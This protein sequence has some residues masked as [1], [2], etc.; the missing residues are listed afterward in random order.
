MHGSMEEIIGALSMEPTLVLPS[1]VQAGLVVEKGA[2]RLDNVKMQA[3]AVR[4]YSQQLYS[5][6]NQE[7]GQAGRQAARVFGWA[8][9][10]GTAESGNCGL[11]RAE[12]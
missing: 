12:R 1:D 8:V 2:S 10:P 11:K 5:A 7:V 4:I 3:V 9:V 6:W